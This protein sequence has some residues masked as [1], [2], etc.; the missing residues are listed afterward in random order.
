MLD[1]HIRCRVMSGE[2]KEEAEVKEELHASISK[3]PVNLLFNP[4]LASRKGIWSISI[5]YLLER[6]L[7]ILEQM[8]SK[9]LRLCGV[10]ALSS[11][12][13]FRLKVESIFMLERIANQH[14]QVAKEG[15]SSSSNS[16]VDLSS[17]S[18][19]MP[20]RHEVAYDLT[21]EDLLEMLS[22]IVE[23][24]YLSSKQGAVD[25]TSTDL[26]IEP[27]GSS[28]TGIDDYLITLERLIDDYKSRL[29]ALVME[30]GS[31]S[32]NGLTL[33]L[34]PIEV[35]RYFIALL[36]LCIDGKVDVLEAADDDILISI[37]STSSSCTTQV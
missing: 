9:D 12:I 18:L 4:S 32:F 35:A 6:F 20:Y 14:R 5:S 13:I 22:S 36:H 25:T 21:L 7:S 3:P 10:A 24:I 29:Y 23:R 15:N 37:R 17:I 31:I 19:E 16:M 30:Q 27:V 33:G 1:E 26:S 2:G 28:L 34:E 11:A 8:R